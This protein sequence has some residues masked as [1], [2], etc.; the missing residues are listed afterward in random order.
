MAEFAQQ[1]AP[2]TPPPRDR[3]FLSCLTSPLAPPPSA[4]QGLGIGGPIVGADF[5]F[6][7]IVP[8][9]PMNPFWPPPPPP[10]N[11]ISTALVPF[12]NP[13]SSALV[14]VSTVLVPFSNALEP[15]PPRRTC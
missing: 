6:G 1:G 9:V 14:P 11:P 8:H 4:F 7:A 15:Q 13:S 2:Q 3:A 5:H 10:V 12:R